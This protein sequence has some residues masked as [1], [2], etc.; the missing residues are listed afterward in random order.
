MYLPIWVIILLIFGVIFLCKAAS[1]MGYNE[2]HDM[3]EIEAEI[4]KKNWSIF[5]EI[6]D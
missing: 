2:G 3:A 5:D 1:E 6:G 4:D